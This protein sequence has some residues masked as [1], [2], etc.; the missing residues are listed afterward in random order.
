MIHQIK[1]ILAI[2]LINCSLIIGQAQNNTLEQDFKNLPPSGKARTMWFWIN[3]NVSQ[4]GITA[5]LEAMK[6]I[7]LQG[8]LIFNVSLQHPSGAASYLSPEWLDLFHFAALEAQRLGLELSFH[9]GAGWSS[10][11]GPSITPEYEMQEVVYAELTVQGGKV[12]KG[13]LPQPSIKL[14]YYKDIAIL[15]FPKPKSNERISHLDYKTLSGKVRNHLAPEDKE[16]ALSAIVKKTDIIN[17]TS[18]ITE[19]GLLEWEVPKGEWI[20]L[21]LGHTPT[22]SKNRFPSDGGAGL[23]CDKMNSAAVDV[24][25]EGGIMP[26]INKLD[27]LIGSVVANCHVDS[28]EVG[29]TNWTANFANDFMRL[30]SY[31][32]SMY[33][34]ALAGYYIESGEETERFLWDF[35]RTIGDL[36]ATNYYGRF[37]ELCHQ[38]GMLFST[39]PYW[40]PFDNMQVGANADAV[41]SEFWSGHLAFFDSPKFVASIAKLNGSA[42]A[43]AEAFTDEGGWQR[44]PGSLK[45]IADLA[46]A[47]GINR[48][49]IHCYAHQPWNVAPG[50]TLDRFGIDF[51]RHNTW[52]KQGKP[53]L[54]YIN[55]GQFLLQQGTTVADVLVFTGEA[56]PNDALLIP[57]IKA[58][59][60]DY[61]LVGSNKI[62]SLTVNE[63]LILTEHGAT[64]KA[65]LLPQNSWITPETLSKLEALAKGGATILGAKPKKSPSLKRYPS[66]DVKVAQFAEELW[67]KGLIKDISVLDFLKNGALPPDVSI[68]QVSGNDFD[69]THRKAADTDIYFVVNKQKESRVLNCRFRVSGMQPELWNAESG[70]ITKAIVWKDNGD[71]TTSIPIQFEAEGSVF[72]VFRSFENL[73][74][75]IVNSKMN[76]E[77]T[78]AKSLLGLNIIKAEYGTFLPSGLVDVTEKVT[79][80]V[81]NNQL[82]IFANRDLCSGDP[83]PGYHK[84]LRLQYSIGGTIL[85][86]YAKEKELLKIDAGDKG[87]LRI[88]KAVFGKFERGVNGIPPS[89]PVYNVTEDIKAKVAAGILE[90]PVNDRFIQGKPKIKTPK[91]LRVTYASVSGEKTIK[92]P[93]GSALKLSQ[94]MPEPKLVS[95]NGKAIWKTPFSGALTYTTLQGKTKTVKVKS[96]PEPIELSGSW[97]VQFPNIEEIT[98]DQ[99]ISWPESTNDNVRYFSGTATYTKEFKVSKKL[100]K[101]NNSLELDL[102]SVKE[103]AEVIVNGQN[104]GILWKPPFRVNMDKAVKQGV[105]TIEVRVTNL[106][107]NRLIGDEQLPLDYERKGN[108]IKQWPDWLIND[109]ERPTQRTTFP[110]YKHWEKE[111]ELLPSGLLGPVRIVVFKTTEL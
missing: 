49:V 37:R 111:S 72:V 45:A 106:W 39:E 54:D 31:D 99:L 7:G 18:K 86:T 109:T 60:Y 22:G 1:T 70:E 21:R 69:F 14:G 58:L 82:E 79:S 77:K 96:V 24:F 68:E 83:A 85:E 8:A 88:L 57:Q 61:D 34:P 64:Y 63:G 2:L 44:D 84:E 67:G 94:D 33:L 12:F 80:S 19:A 71:G 3:G 16:V 15:A 95:K 26:I 36:I 59:G 43:E 98:F 52:W 74:E 53:F 76:I 5:D 55:R 101:E 42:I 87:E 25:W 62:A 9:N 20:I 4:E 41:L 27:T 13:Q 78:K 46:W 38:Y 107:P 51:N 100:M 89:N 103:I 102:G 28:Y 23:E 32:C 10:T 17:V 40:G 66:S 11:G 104:L 81:Q 29:T 6:E 75:H 110:A 56:S 92:V 105:N 65:L 35:R 50:L 30:R 108:R 47:Q 97:N 90:I 93:Y 73:S 48:F 91:T